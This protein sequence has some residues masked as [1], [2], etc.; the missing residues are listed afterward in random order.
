MKEFYLR[1]GTLTRLTL[2]SWIS[3]RQFQETVTS[4]LC[5]THQAKYGTPYA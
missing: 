4:I 3:L 2:L 5:R 1:L